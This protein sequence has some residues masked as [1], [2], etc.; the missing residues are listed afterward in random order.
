MNNSKRL[1]VWVRG[2]WRDNKTWALSLAIP[3][4]GAIPLYIYAISI[5]QLPDFSIG[6]LT[7]VLI[8]SFLT[9]AF[10]GTIMVGYL[11]IAGFAAR[12]VVTNFYPDPDAET[13]NGG[14]VPSLSKQNA[15]RYL[16][17][18]KFIAGVAAFDVLVWVSRKAIRRLACS[19]V[20]RVRKIRILHFVG[21][22]LAAGAD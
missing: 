19:A 3:L 22:D 16:I 1:I 8:A 5:G 9:E 10:L 15:Y 12:S 17:K 7:G 14:I 20:R 4:V 6:D 18:G 13:P 2:F 11:L 21:C